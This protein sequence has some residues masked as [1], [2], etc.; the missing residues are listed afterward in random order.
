MIY[1]NPLR[2]KCLIRFEVT[3]GLR[4]FLKSLSYLNSRVYKDISNIIY[5]FRIRD[6]SISSQL[7]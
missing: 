5:I 1:I 6:L 7:S 3:V 2:Y 4:H